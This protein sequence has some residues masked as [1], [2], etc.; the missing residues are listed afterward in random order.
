MVS[1]KELVAIVHSS[2][3]GTSLPTPTQRIELTH[4]IRN[5]FSS[6]QNLLSFPPPKPSDRAQVQSKEIR[7]PDSLPISLDDQDVAISLKLSDELHLNEIDSV[8]LLVSANQEWGLMGRDPLEIQRLATGLW[9]TG[10]RDLTSTLY[11]LL[12]A[13]VLDQGLEPDLIADIQGLLEE[14][15]KAGLRQRLI[16][17]VKE[18]NRQD[19]TGLGGPLCERYLID[20]RGA[21]VERRAVVQRERLILGHCL[22]LSILVDRP[23]SKDV[24]DIYYVFKDNAAQLTEGNDTISSQITF[25]LLFSLIIT[26]VSDAISGLSDKSSM[27]SQDASFRTDFQ[28]IVMASGSDPTADG[29][30]GGIRLAWAVHLMLIHDGISGMDTIS[31]ASTK[32]MGH[33]CSCLESIFS[34]N[35]FQ[36]LLDNVLRTAAYQ[37]D[38]EDMIYIYNAYLHKLASCFLSHPIA[39]DKVK[40]SKD[41]AMSVLNSYRTCDSLDGSMQTEE[42]DR[43]LPFISLMEFV[44]KIYQKEPEL[45]SGN[46]VLWTF[47]NFAGE[48]HTNFKTLVAF[49]EMLCT[50]A[51]TQEGASKVYELLRGTSFRSI[52]W[53]TLFDCIRIYDEKF[54]QSLQTAGAMMPEFLEGDAKA[55]VAYLNVLQKVVENGNPT[56]RKNWFPDIEP[57]FKLLGYENI[58]PY[59]KG[60]LRKT[61]AAFVNVFPEMRDSIWAFLEQYDLPVVVGSPVGKSDQ[62]SQVY[63]MQFELNEVEARREQYPSTISFLNLINALI[64]GEKDVNDRGRRFIGI[65]RFVY[66]HVFT[67]FP[68]RAYSDPCEKWQLVVACLQHFHMILSMYDIQE[69]DLDGF[70]EHPHFLVSV[71]TSSLQTQLPIIELLKDFMSGKALYRNLMGI[72]QVGVNAI[73]SERL[74]K[75]YGKILEKAVQ[76]SLEI[77]LLVF[78]KDLLVSDVWRPLYQPLDIIL[79][80]DHNQ[81]IALLEY[82]RYDSLPQIQRSS[83]KIMNILSSR[84]VGLVPMLIKIDAAN[85]LI[86]DYAACLEVRLEEGEVVENSCDDL[87]VLIMQLLVDNINRPAPSITHL[88]LKF[89]LDAPVEGTV[90]QPKFHYSCLKV[91]LEMLEKLPNPDIN[92]LLFEFGFQLLCELNLDP[93]TSGPTMDL[94][95][96]KKYQFFLQHLDTIGVA[97]LPKRSGSQALRISSLHQRAW[98]LK[99]LAIALHTGSG[100]SSA[101]LE[102]CQSILSHLF[103][104]EVT[105]AANEPFSSSTYPQDGLDYTGTSS[106]SKSKALALLEIL[107]FRSPD[108]SMQLPQIVSSLK[109]DSLV[110][111]I[112]E[113]RDNSVSGSIYYYSERGDRLIDLSSFSNKLWQKLHSGFPLVD[114]FPNVA[115]LSEVRETIQQLLKWGWKYNRNLEEQAAQL[116]MLAGWSQIVEVSACRRISSLDNRSEILYRIL[117]ASL[118]AS[119]SPDCSLKMAFVLTQ[120][121]L[122]CI[123]KL[124]D[125]RFSFQGA[126]SS[127]TVTCLDVMM[128]KHLSTGACHSVLFKLVMAILRHESSESLRRRQYALLLSYF[129]YCQHMIALDVPTSVVQFLLL[130]EQDGEDLDIQKID[131]EQADLARANF[132]IIKK[133]AQGILDLVIKDAS[134]GSEFGKTISLY[135]LEALVCIDHERYFLSQL[136]SRGFIRSCLGSISNISYQDGTHL[137]E[138]QQRA[139]TLEAEFA[140]LLRISHKY[141]KS[142]GQV[143]FSMGALEHIASCRAISFKGNMRRVDMKLQSDVGYNVQKQ[144]TIIT[145]VLRLMFAL[146]SLVE[147]SEFFEGR[148]KIVREVIE[149]IKGH[150]FLF[151]QLLREDFTQADDLLMEQII[152]AVGILSKVWPF[153]ENDG[154]GFVQGLFDMMSNLFIVSPI[155]LISSQ[156]GSELK[157]SQL[158]FSLTSYLYFLVTKN[159]LRLQVSDDSL[160]SS[161]KLRQPTLL[162]LASLLSHVT[163]SL[164]RAAEKKSLL[165]H[166]IRDINELSRQDVD[167]IIKICDCQ[168]YVTPSDN[169]HKR[170]YIAMVEMCQIVG[171]RDQLITLLLQLAEH[172]LNIILIHLQDRSVSSNERGSYGSKSHLQQDVT[173]LCGKLSP[174]IERLALLNEGKVGHNLKVF[175]RLATTVKEMAIQK[176][177]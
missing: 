21:L 91:I 72:L 52:G 67:P 154:Y 16:T 49:L 164:E 23:G 50:L 141:G 19:P 45:L 65:F 48:D 159:S 47:V 54:K 10:R 95:S 24:K 148:N 83:I 151:D 133:E 121:A 129:Q 7:L 55:L 99:L 123:A 120:V 66:D 29:F 146:T 109:Y 172:V 22:V 56:E 139:C 134:Q 158:R 111:D 26:F 171:N 149:F 81:I 68:Q 176:C 15:I 157:L 12:R 28:D 8:R 135:V 75:T 11:T 150:Q 92:F 138:S 144:R 101:H 18:L 96:S 14:L 69:E 153:E 140:L 87:G 116:H 80:Q 107:Q 20:S 85:S 130:N 6:I 41:M 1:P 117:D 108:T 71:E 38:E 88:L 43:P 137:L 161:T 46:D 127:D 90:L 132:F 9:Y 13:V 169:I 61:I 126:L 177:L 175:Q 142:G 105:E 97:T 82:V 77:L 145:A 36:F 174:T 31:T 173:D 160:D 114:S 5:S 168:E 58:P 78:E 103:G 4:A 104:R 76:L 33:I 51:S 44:S 136:Q 122:T 143:L 62:S 125:D 42:A 17:L 34:K 79:S 73:I 74:S 39:R 84:L 119:A 35:V 25:S 102:A 162:L 27:I 32:D 59:L 165:L 156:K 167:A 147:T 93:L 163:D 131:K 170:R 89:D 70:T 112:L 57:F 53:P 60:A 113:N 106:I 110:E 2:L 128:V 152:L 155:K 118:S 40:E 98:L 115:E 94:L 3:L 100:S 166:K 124:R 63:D 64:A 30:I 37:N 86:E